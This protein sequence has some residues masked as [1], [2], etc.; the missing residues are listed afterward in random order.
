MTGTVQ[1]SSDQPP[2]EAPDF[3]VFHR[4]AANFPWRSHAVWFISQM[5]RWGQI[6]HAI[7]P[8]TLA[9]AVYR[10]EV[11][12]A[13]ATELGIQYPEIDYKREGIHTEGWALMSGD[14]TIVMGPDR[15]MDEREFDANDVPGYLAGFDQTHMKVGL[16]A[17]TAAIDG[18]PPEAVNDAG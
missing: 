18:T 15:F 12:R 5:L 11:Y 6:D 7:K 13:A 10:P 9:A 8:E 16:D 4:Y 3:N 14:D 17:L 2:R 1:L